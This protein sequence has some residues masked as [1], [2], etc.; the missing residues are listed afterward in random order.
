MRVC[1]RYEPTNKD[2]NEYMS[3]VDT[4]CYPGLSD[5]DYKA[6]MDSHYRIVNLMSGQDPARIQDSLA[7]RRAGAAVDL[8]A[9]L[10]AEPEPEPEAEA[11]SAEDAAGAPSGAPAAEGAPEP[12]EVS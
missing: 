7:Q 10:E 1:H 3:V 6:L 4:T 2:L 8:A 9:A 11:P 12:A 5:D